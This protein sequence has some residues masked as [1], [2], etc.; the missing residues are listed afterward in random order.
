M[1]DIGLDP[2]AVDVFPA[3]VVV[4]AW[5]PPPFLLLL[6]E[7][8]AP[9]RDTAKAVSRLQF[10]SVAHL[11]RRHSL[12]GPSSSLVS[13]SCSSMLSTSAATLG[14]ALSSSISACSCRALR[15]L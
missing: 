13:A 3:A 10:Y 9:A 2:L 15:R 11:K 8:V 5:E 1:P 6:G 7:V 14:C 4:W 12:T